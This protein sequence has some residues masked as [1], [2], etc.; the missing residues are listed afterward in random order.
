MADVLTPEQRQ[1]CMAAIQGMDTKPEM[2]VRRLVHRMGYRFRLHRR[3][4]PGCPD[5]VF[6]SRGAVIFVSGCFWHRHDCP[7]GRRLPKTRAAW[8]RAKLE[9]NRKRDVA[10]QRRLRRAG[11]RVMVIW[12]CQLRDIDRVAGRITRFLGRN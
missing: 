5:L 4:L 9:A 12:E 1:R 11:W 8:W 7:N 2:V 6:P 3:D 10:V